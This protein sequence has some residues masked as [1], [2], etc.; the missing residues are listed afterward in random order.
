MHE[1][2]NKSCVNNT[3]YDFSYFDELV[4]KGVTHAVFD[5]DNTITKSNIVQLYLFMKK[6]EARSKFTWLLWFVFFCVT[7]APFFMVMDKIDRARCQRLIY[8]LYRPYSKQTLDSEAKALFDEVLSHRFIHYVHDLLIHLKGKG[9]NVV[10]LSTNLDVVAKQYGEYFGVAYEGVS[11]NRLIQSSTSQYG[12][13][14]KKASSIEYLDQFKK[15]FIKNFEQSKT[16]ALAD[17]IY[18]LP[19]LDYVDYPVLVTQKPQ[20]WMKLQPHQIIRWKK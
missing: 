12:E 6:R 15:R 7:Y 3:T 20:A 9:V 11:L 14:Q 13:P 8:K 17:S 10:L 19:V 2:I 5:I 18:D 1:L 16:L 4:E